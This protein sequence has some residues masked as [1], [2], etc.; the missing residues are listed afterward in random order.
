[1]VYMSTWVKRWM[2]G[3]TSFDTQELQTLADAN[4]LCQLNFQKL[5]DLL[6]ANST[7]FIATDAPS[8]ADH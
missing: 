3:Q 1:M 7:K 6:S 5:E 4:N 8:I 2:T